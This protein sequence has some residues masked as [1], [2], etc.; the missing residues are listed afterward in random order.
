[1]TR[2]RLAK[3]RAGAETCNATRSLLLHSYRGDYAT[4]LRDTSPVGLYPIFTMDFL[5]WTISP[6][7]SK[8]V[9]H[10]LQ[11]RSRSARLFGFGLLLVS[12]IPAADRV[13]RMWAWR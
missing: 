8:V 11:R 1:V 6:A 7:C 13:V 10:L 5:R 2:C 4:N 9:L 12:G 3:R